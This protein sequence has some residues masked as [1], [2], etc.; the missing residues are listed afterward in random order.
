MEGAEVRQEMESMGT[1]RGRGAIVCGLLTGG[2]ADEPAERQ[3]TGQ[4]RNGDVVDKGARSVRLGG[5]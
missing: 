4:R 5:E 1:R 3:W 2:L